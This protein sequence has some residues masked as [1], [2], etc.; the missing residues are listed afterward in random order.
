MSMNNTI[1]TGKAS[2]CSSWSSTLYSILTPAPYPVNLDGTHKNINLRH[3]RHSPGLIWKQTLGYCVYH[4]LSDEE[5]MSSPVRQRRRFAR[6][7][8]LGLSGVILFEIPTGRPAGDG[9]LMTQNESPKARITLK[10]IFG[11]PDDPNESGMNV[12]ELL[13]CVNARVVYFPSYACTSFIMGQVMSAFFQQ[14][15]SIRPLPARE[16]FSVDA[17]AFLNASFTIGESFIQMSNES[18]SSLSLTSFDLSVAATSSIPLIKVHPADDDDFFRSDN[19]EEF[20]LGTSASFPTLGYNY[21]TSKYDKSRRYSRYMEDECKDE[22]KAQIRNGLL[23]TSSSL[24]ERKEDGQV[25]GG[26]GSLDSGGFMTSHPSV[27]SLVLDDY[28]QVLSDEM[29]GD[30][31][32]DIADKDE[33]NTS[34]STLDSG[35]LQTPPRSSSPVLLDMEDENSSDK[36]LDPTNACRRSQRPK[37]LSLSSVSFFLEF[38]SDFSPEPLTP[39]TMNTSGILREQDRTPTHIRAPMTKSARLGNQSWTKSRAGLGKENIAPIGS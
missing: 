4:D 21:K 34:I 14:E 30:T 6:L 19:P 27:L 26:A 28:S 23:L 37:V 7:E 31:I 17:E 10:T 3:N 12:N 24:S 33:G 22:L 35:G 9:C 20:E 39:V 15:P 1:T 18:C 32:A 36:D 25:L 2:P 11:D 5:S 29:T 8:S 16:G 13:D 38:E